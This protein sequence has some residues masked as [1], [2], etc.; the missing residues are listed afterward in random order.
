[1]MNQTIGFTG[2]TREED[3]LTFKRIKAIEDIP[4]LNVKAGTMG[5]WV[6]EGSTIEE[7]SWV[8][9]N[10]VLHDSH[11]KGDI[12]LKRNAYVID[13]VVQG[14]G[15]IGGDSRINQSTV[16]VENITVSGQTLIHKSKVVGKTKESSLTLS[17]KSHI[18]KSDI[19]IVDNQLLMDGTSRL[20]LIEGKISGMVLDNAWIRTSEIEGTAISLKDVGLMEYSQIKGD[21]IVLDSIHQVRKTSFKGSNLYIGSIGELSSEQIEGTN[22]HLEKIKEAIGEMIQ[23][24]L[25]SEPVMLD[26]LFGDE[27]SAQ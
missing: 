6:T 9:N 19:T 13:S 5:G 15:V 25:K 2:E 4:S 18:I 3:G 24:A 16:Q 26:E 10:A 27:V 22:L 14:N 11:L 20:I 17:D 7:G 8:A 1:M 12:L 21:N 23:E